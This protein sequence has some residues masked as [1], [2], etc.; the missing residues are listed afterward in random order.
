M[1][2]VILQLGQ[3]HLHAVALA[4]VGRLPGWATEAV[5]LQ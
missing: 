1:R 2:G 5:T 4:E 3:A